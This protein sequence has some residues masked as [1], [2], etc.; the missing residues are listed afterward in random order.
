VDWWEN[1]H[2]VWGMI[3]DDAS[4]SVVENMYALPT[5]TDGMRMLDEKIAFSIELI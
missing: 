1:Q 3:H 4:L 2:T 5:H